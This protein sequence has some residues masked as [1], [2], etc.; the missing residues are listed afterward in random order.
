M[1]DSLQKD[2]ATIEAVWAAQNRSKKKPSYGMRVKRSVARVLEEEE[3]APSAGGGGGDD[4]EAHELVKH[5]AFLSM[6][7]SLFVLPGPPFDVVRREVLPLAAR[8]A[9]GQS[10]AF[11]PAALATI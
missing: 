3:E 8:L 9:R 5:G 6:W 4:C 1:S 2:V 7:L 10:M 11:A